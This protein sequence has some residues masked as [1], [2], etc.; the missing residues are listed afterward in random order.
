MPNPN[1]ENYTRL[2]QKTPPVICEQSLNFTVADGYSYSA[3]FQVLRP[4]TYYYYVDK[5][6][7]RPNDEVLARYAEQQTMLPYVEAVLAKI[8]GSDTGYRPVF[9]LAKTNDHEWIY[10]SMFEAKWKKKQIVASA[11]GWLTLPGLTIPHRFGLRTHHDNNE[12]KVMIFLTQTPSDFT[13]LQVLISAFHSFGQAC[14][15]SLKTI[16]AQQF[17]SEWR[18][19]ASRFI[20]QNQS[21]LLD[22]IYWPS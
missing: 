17:N 22:T 7:V 19:I 2:Y 14:L 12:H 6:L 11:E 8:D 16:S 21:K 3:D 20:L 1:L 9:C 10:G 18:N 15:M 5:K 13:E 4:Q